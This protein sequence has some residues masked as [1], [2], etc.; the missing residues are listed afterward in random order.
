MRIA[1][2]LARSSVGLTLETEDGPVDFES[3]SIIS[4]LVIVV[5]AVVLHLLSLSM[6]ASRDGS[7]GKELEDLPAPSTRAALHFERAMG[8]PVACAL[9]AVPPPQCF[10]AHALAVPR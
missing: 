4:G 9:R 2:T 10:L 6:A 8:V 3:G 1:T 7:I 5:T